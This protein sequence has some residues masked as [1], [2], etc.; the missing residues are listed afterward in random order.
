MKQEIS[1]AIWNKAL[2]SLW[3]MTHGILKKKYCRVLFI[4]KVKM[5]CDCKKIKKNSNGKVTAISYQRL[6]DNL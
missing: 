2:L 4:S 1:L 6:S 5:F 3:I